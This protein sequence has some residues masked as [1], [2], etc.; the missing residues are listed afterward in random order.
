[1]PIKIASKPAVGPAAYRHNDTLG[2]LCLVCKVIYLSCAT[3]FWFEDLN[4][5]KIFMK[6]YDTVSKI[7]EVIVV[8]F[9]ISEW[10][11]FYTQTHLNEKQNN[12]MYLF[13]FS[14]VVIY[15]VYASALYYKQELRKLVFTLGVRLKEVCNDAVVERMM[16]KTAG[17]YLTGLV[18]VCSSTLISYGFD[19]GVQS[20]T[21]NGVARLL[22]YI[23][24]W[25]FIVRVISTY[26]IILTITIC[27]AHQFANL[28]KYFKSLNSIFEGT[29]SQADK[30]KRYEDAFKV[31]IKMHS[32]TLWCARQTQTTGSVA[33]S[34]QVIINVSVLV[35]L[36]MQM[37]YTERTLIALM[38][39]FFMAASVLVG[40]GV[41]MWNA[42]DVTIEASKL[43]SAMFY[44]GWHNCQ[45]ESSVRVR[46]MVTIAI[47]QA[48]KRVLI[49]G[50]GFMELSYES[51]VKVI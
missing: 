7:L 50:L 9:V 29:G 20:L 33:F 32:I 22:Y 16:V 17:R 31:G 18:F 8:L 47:M 37:M 15:L 44:S 5:Q 14:H 23:I 26:L 11:P 27:L 21:T 2:L 3:N 1:M 43:P 46:K 34:A 41:F 19:S 49:K 4:Y 12:D 38:P 35:L 30:E 28:C 13:A 42:G 36:M 25:I 45:R 40:S 39:I 10:G 48:Q 51:Y 24:W 6:I